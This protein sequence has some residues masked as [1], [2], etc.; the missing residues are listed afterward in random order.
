MQDT[1]YRR[2]NFSSWSEPVDVRQLLLPVG[3]GHRPIGDAA[4]Q[5]AGTS[6][7]LANAVTDLDTLRSVPGNAD[8]FIAALKLADA[9]KEKLVRSRISSEPLRPARNIPRSM[10]HQA[11]ALIERYTRHDWPAMS[12]RRGDPRLRPKCLNFFGKPANWSSWRVVEDDI[13][14]REP[15]G[16]DTESAVNCG[17]GVRWQVFPKRPST[18]Y[19]SVCDPRKW[20]KL[21]PGACSTLAMLIPKCGST[22]MRQLLRYWLKHYSDLRAREL[23]LGEMPGR[24]SGSFV[25]VRDP[26]VRLISAYGTMKERA[27]RQPT[28]VVYKLYP[29]LRHADEAAR[30][31]H[32]AHLL[33]TQGDR[34]LWMEAQEFGSCANNKC[35]DVEK[36]SG[37]CTRRESPLVWMHAMSQMYYLQSYPYPFDYVAHLETVDADLAEVE[38]K[39]RFGTIFSDETQRNMRGNNKTSR[40]NANQGRLNMTRLLLEAPAAVADLLHYLRHDYACLSDYQVRSR[41]VS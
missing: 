40:A 20:H 3:P 32:F 14:R 16:N 18:G 33:R 39:F 37:R 41:G 22:S 1:Q 10:L 25:V 13:A 35:T 6:W 24:L 17:L 38:K 27:S 30:F 9:G 5:N 26:L 12:W 28:S 7:L 19:A 29:F 21:P 15:T 11:S 8:R 4:T 34:L 31:S 36:A 23:P 2:A